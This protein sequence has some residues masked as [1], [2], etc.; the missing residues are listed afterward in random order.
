MKTFNFS[1]WAVTVLSIF[2]A[3]TSFGQQ[4]YNPKALV[5]LDPAFKTGVLGNGIKYILRGDLSE[6]NAYFYACVDLTKY[7][8]HCSRF[9]LA[10]FVSIFV[11]EKR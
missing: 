4:I 7:T 5:T 9:W 1:V 8:L 2:M 3:G 10:F 11:K 6:K